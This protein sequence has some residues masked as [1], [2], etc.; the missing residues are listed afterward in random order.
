MRFLERLSLWNRLK[1]DG[2][3]ENLILEEEMSCQC[4]STFV[5]I[6]HVLSRAGNPA[7]LLP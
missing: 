3:D 6:D 5:G 2:E 1:K 4:L 7:A